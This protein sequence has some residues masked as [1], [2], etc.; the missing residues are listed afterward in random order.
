MLCQTYGLKLHVIENFR[1]NGQDVICHQLVNSSGSRS[2]DEY[3]NI[4]NDP[5]IIHILNE[6]SGHFVPILHKTTLLNQPI[7]KELCASPSESPEE[8]PVNNE[9]TSCSKKLQVVNRRYVKVCSITDKS[10]LSVVAAEKENADFK[11]LRIT[12][13]PTVTAALEFMQQAE[14]FDIFSLSFHWFFIVIEVDYCSPFPLT[15]LDSLVDILDK[16][17]PVIIQWDLL[18]SAEH[19][20]FFKERCDSVFSQLQ[21]NSASFFGTENELIVEL[22]QQVSFE[23]PLLLNAIKLGIGCQFNR[24]ALDLL[25]VSFDVKE[26]IDTWRLIDYAARYGDRLSLR[27]LMLDNWD[28]AHKIGDGRSTLEIAVEYGGAQSLSALLN[29]PV[30][31][32]AEEKFMYSEEKLLLASRKYVDNSLLIAAEKE[33]PETLQFLISCGAD[34]Q[35]HNRRNAKDSAIQKAWDKERYENMCLFLDA[36]SPF[37]DNFDLCHLKKGENT[38]ALFDQVEDREKLH[39]AIKDGVQTNVKE[40]IRHH[41]RLKRAYDPRNKSALMTAFEAAQYEVYVL[42][43]SEGLCAGKNEHPVFVK[44]L[45]TEEQKAGI[46]QANLK[47]FGKEDDSHI[48]YL[49]SKSRLGIG[50][51]KNQNFG[52]IRKLYKQL[53]SIPE[54]STILKEVEQSELREIIFD[55]ENDSIVDLDPNYS[56]GNKGSFNHNEGLIYIG[57]K[58]VS[59]LLG[60][61]AHELSHLA[62]LVC[63]DNG[64]CPY[65]E[66]DEQTKCE[67]SKIVSKYSEKV[68]MDM[69]IERVF[70]GY[71]KSI[72]HAELI[73]R[74]PHLLAHYSVDKDKL[75]LTQQQAPELFKLYVQNTQKDLSRFVETMLILSPGIKFST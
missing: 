48:I 46:K 23:L 2:M 55:F 54:I 18:H 7:E 60:I 51:E 35:C 69:I 36:D 31:I 15:A 28:L 34:I 40:F 10:T 66:S 43:Q 9:S 38:V 67:F 26:E 27:F 58:E 41:T 30:I 73:V 70:T 6:G 47:Y 53:N 16:Q 4:Y 71:D 57:A 14:F 64:W 12:N 13:C 8:G 68:G 3:S 39:Q 5:Q 1:L 63:Y 19:L 74:V 33:K 37:P 72:W 75:L 29:L 21:M 56:S 32:S 49:L 61:L 42:L 52:K 44:E 45:L 17:K 25:N 24:G 20:V 65:E 22:F 50:Q 59:E 62:M 11:I